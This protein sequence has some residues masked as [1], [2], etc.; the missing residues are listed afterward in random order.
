MAKLY[1]P[2]GAARARVAH[3]ADLY[4]DTGNVAAAWTCWHVA[5]AHGLPVPQAVAAEIDRFAQA[6]AGVIESATAGDRDARLDGRTIARLWAGE[7]GGRG[8]NE[9]AGAVADW[10]RDL[11]ASVDVI[12]RRDGGETEASAVTSV[13]HARG[14]S[15]SAVRAAV[16]RFRPAPEDVSAKDAI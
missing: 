13:A 3:L 1:D 12:R 15:E 11:A 4:R 8:K 7:A 16:R 14:M 2:E 9:P 6:I 10:Q 5:R